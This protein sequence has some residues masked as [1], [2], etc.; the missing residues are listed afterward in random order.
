MKNFTI[1]FQTFILISL[2]F[3]F[4]LTYSQVG[5]GTTSPAYEFHVLNNGNVG[6]TSLSTSENTGT[7]GVAFTGINTS[8][9][10]GYNGIEGVTYGQYSGVFGL[11][12]SD[13]N[14]ST[15][16]AIGVY[17]HAND[18][19]GVGVFGVRSGSG[20][21]NN[22]FAGLFLGTL[23]YSGGLVN[24]SDRRVKT[25]IQ[26]IPSAL[27]LI[28]QLNPV[29]YRFNSDAY[30]NLGLVD[31]IEYGFIAQ[32]LEEIIPNLVQSKLID[33]NAGKNKGMYEKP[34]VDKQLFK[35]VNYIEMIPLL[36][37]AVQEQQLLID[38]QNS[39][40]ESIETKILLLESLVNQMLDK[41][42]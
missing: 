12:F 4:N 35:M 22:G 28:T 8:T 30:P 11:G 24:L 37:K 5:V 40:I 25:D 16:D 13:D 32:E 6:A 34:D 42:N 19:Q 10:N 38:R 17:G 33:V 29:S 14:G 1:Y 7:D 21:P 15:Y 9:I 39:K 36:T 2:F 41:Q 20:G 27:S 3:T 31:N 18:Y 26:K 23:G